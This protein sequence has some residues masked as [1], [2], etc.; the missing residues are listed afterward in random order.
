M[1]DV[2]RYMIHERYMLLHLHN[3]INKKNDFERVSNI[4]LFL[5]LYNWDGIE[6]PTD[7]NKNNYALF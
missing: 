7:I 1:I 6:Y 4:K 5:N 3:T 2:F